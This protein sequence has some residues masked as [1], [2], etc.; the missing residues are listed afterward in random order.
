MSFYVTLPSGGSQISFSG[1]TAAKY[2]VKLAKN[3]PLPE[4]DW[5]VALTSV[6]FPDLVS[7][8]AESKDAIYDLKTRIPLIM[9]YKMICKVLYV[10]EKEIPVKR[11]GKHVEDK[12]GETL[13]YHQVG[14]SVRLDL[15]DLGVR[16]L[17]SI[18]SGYYFWGRMTDLLT[19]QMYRTFEDV[20][21][22]RGDQG[23][24]LADWKSAVTKKGHHP[25]FEWVSNA[26]TYDL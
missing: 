10:D 15:E 11:G 14:G 16:F 21:D 9:N 26:D 3:I 4:K 22:I 17:K 24:R 20:D 25:Y 19:D 12:E 5:E 2:T 8:F 18:Q 23:K 6:S 7:E 13:Y 1:N